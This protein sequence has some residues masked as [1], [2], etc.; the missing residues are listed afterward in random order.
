MRLT[1]F[2]ATV[3]QAYKCMH[4]NQNLARELTQIRVEEIITSDEF[5]DMQQEEK[6]R[7]VKVKKYI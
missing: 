6:R 2:F 3:L 4:N 7:R 5:L 1:S